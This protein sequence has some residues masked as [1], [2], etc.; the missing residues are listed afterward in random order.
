MIIIWELSARQADIDR[1]KTN[2][3]EKNN[4]RSRTMVS[5]LLPLLSGEDMTGSAP[6]GFSYS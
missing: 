5:C 1:T 3:I 4:F 6:D 2:R